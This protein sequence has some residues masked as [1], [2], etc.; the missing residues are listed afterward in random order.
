MTHPHTVACVNAE[1]IADFADL[2]SEGTPKTP[3]GDGVDDGRNGAVQSLPE[4]VAADQRSDH[5]QILPPVSVGA[6]VFDDLATAVAEI[7]RLRKV[8]RELG[9]AGTT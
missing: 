5:Q 2:I 1:D 8:V 6:E 3:T 4:D 7:S 9:S